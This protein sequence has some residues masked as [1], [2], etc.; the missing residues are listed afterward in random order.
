[1]RHFDTIIIGLGAMGSS[2]AYYLSRQ[3]ARVLGLEQHAIPNVEGSSHGFS[4]MIRMAY[5]E[6]P[7]YVPLLRKA[8]ELWDQLEI[9]SPQTLFMRTGTLYLGK[10]ES[11][12]IAGSKRAAGTHHIPHEMLSAAEVR[13]YSPFVIPDDFVGFY[14][15]SGGMLLP[16]RV[17]SRFCFM[18]MMHGGELHGHER[19]VSWEERGERVEVISER[20]KYEADS[21]IICAGP[22]TGKVL[23][24]LG[25]PLV[26]TRQVMGWVWPE[27][28]WRYSLGSFP[29]WAVDV[30]GGA[31]LYGFPMHNN[32]V[33]LKVAHHRRGRASDPDAV[34]RRVGE[35]DEADFRS[36]MATYLPEAN[37]GALLAMRTCLYTN[38]PDGHFIIDRVPGC[39]RAF[40]AGGFSGHGFKFAPVVGKILAE[41]AMTGGTGEPIELFRIGRF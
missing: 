15:P 1:M 25:L 18:A 33:G 10:G 11:E 8:Y 26:V 3:G 40:I 28:P 41:L 4:R 12:L 30:G 32:D 16:E 35:G 27:K 37:A 13:G 31:L 29:T 5:Y 19:V 20:G 24:A 38:T 17:V 7:D 39:Q 2:A 21:V 22:W 36:G 23:G 9:S 14:E 6:H 34:D